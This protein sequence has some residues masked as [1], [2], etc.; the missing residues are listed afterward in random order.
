MYSA[1]NPFRAPP[2]RALESPSRRLQKRNSMAASSSSYQQQQ[3]VSGS[4]DVSSP[5]YGPMFAAPTP[6]STSTSS[7]ASPGHLQQQ[8]QHVDVP[9][10][11]RPSTASSMPLEFRSGGTLST[12][13]KK[14]RDPPLAWSS[15]Q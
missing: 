8:H 7:S 15:R 6:T 11:N 14:N 5:S 4:G 2:P 1:P 10:N 13:D 12:N 3:R 9:P